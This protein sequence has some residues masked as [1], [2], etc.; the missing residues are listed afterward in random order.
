[1]KL[2]QLVIAHDGRAMDRRQPQEIHV[3]LFNN[4]IPPGAARTVHYRFRVPSD[5]TGS[6]LLAAAANYRKFSRDY[7]IFVGGKDAP[8]LPVPR[9]PAAP[10]TRPVAPAPAGTLT[11]EAKRGNPDWPEK[12][13]IRWN[14]YGIGLLLQ[15]DLKGASSAFAKVADLAAD[16]PDGP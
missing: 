6:I 7:S 16:K 11:A 9:I 8:V 4:F 14:D 12:Q 2:S 3:P 5:A 10:V 15:G 1:D 13:W